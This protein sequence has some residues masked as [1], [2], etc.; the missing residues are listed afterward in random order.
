MEGEG[1]AVLGLC[2]A[3]WRYG[4]GRYGVGPKV[5]GARD[6]VPDAV[7]GGCEC[8]GECAGH[9]EVS[10]KVRGRMSRRC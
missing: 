8:D 9:V 5:C 2:V 1:G 10:F 6:G 4:G 7:Y 3:S